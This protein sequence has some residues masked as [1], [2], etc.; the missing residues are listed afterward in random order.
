MNKDAERS[1]LQS[2]LPIPPAQE[3]IL[4]MA[5]LNDVIKIFDSTIGNQ[6]GIGSL[7]SQDKFAALI[8]SCRENFPPSDRYLK[9]VIRIFV[10]Q[11]EKNGGVIE[12]DELAEIIFETMRSKEVAPNPDESS[13]LSFYVPIQ[14]KTEAQGIAPI[15]IRQFAYHND[16]SLR[17]WE[18]GAFLAEYFLANKH[19]SSG[20]KLIELGA[21]VGL[22]GLVVAGCCGASGVHMTDHTDAC[23]LNIEHNIATNEEWLKKSGHSN[24]SV[25]QV[26]CRASYFLCVA[27]T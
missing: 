26:C 23:L 2:N 27:H 18:A 11:V 17:L 1:N 16:V 3:L 19:L 8:G 24:A 22:T 6:D 10:N 15:R 12:S 4:A 14:N 21:G 7:E 25:T 13:Y 5:P 20:K 9:A